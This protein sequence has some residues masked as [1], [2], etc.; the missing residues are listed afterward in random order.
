MESSDKEI[1][2]VAKT[3]TSANEGWA[4]R[5]VFEELVQ[6]LHETKRE[7]SERSPGVI[8]TERMGE[9]LEQLSRLE[10][11]LEHIGEVQQSRLEIH[12][13]TQIA[14]SL[15]SALDLNDVLSLILDSLK[16]VVD[17]DAAGI[18]VLSKDGNE[19]EGEI[20]RGYRSSKRG[21]VRQKFGQGLMGWAME[22]MA[23][24]VVSDVS[25]DPRYIDA[26]SRTRS[27]LVVPMFTAGRVI[28]A[29]N[30]ESDRLGAF[31]ERDANH[32]MTFASHAS[33]AIERARLHREILEKNK[34]DEEL[35]LARRMQKDLLPDEAPEYERFKIAGINRPS[36]MVGGDYYDYI[37]LTHKDLGLVIGDV[38]GKGIPAA[39]TMAS[40]RAALRIEASSH[41]AIST[42]LAR[43]NDF[44]NDSTKP[45]IFVTAF[46]GV[47]D[48]QTGDLTYANG[49][50]N[51]PLLF[52]KDG[53]VQEL[54][55]GGML[56]GA[57]PAALYHEHRVT[58]N[59]GDVLLFY[60][61]G[62]TEAENDSEQQ[63]GVERLKEAVSVLVL[64]SPSH[65]ISELLKEISGFCGE[66]GLQ[67][68]ITLM[69]VQCL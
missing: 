29:F 47:L 10:H 26:R 59:S 27:E 37:P 39:F 28:G 15:A 32:L 61:D 50:H 9:F 51:P 13:I 42:I 45:E 62:A 21:A 2:A 16:Q 3:A 40:F 69:V 22:N 56:L 58:L 55:E 35:S 6:L 17:Y 33:V 48:T 34:I 20:L 54:S 11:L 63:F 36:E 66:S 43:V 41:Y 24:L 38:V 60:T 12:L 67:D 64:E 5:R 53:Q 49:G 30:L 46:Y 25:R 44:L 19:M 8:P 14:L 68:D 23:P 7:I 18:F 65:I 1:S 31:S 52:R 57:F 4:E